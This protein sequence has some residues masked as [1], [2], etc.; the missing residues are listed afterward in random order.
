MKIRNGFVSN[1]SSSS[2]ILDKRTKGVEKLIE[3]AQKNGVIDYTDL[4]RRTTVLIGKD[5][6]RRYMSEHYGFDYE[7]YGEYD[8][9]HKLVSL[10]NQLNDNI[11]FMRES[12]EG[13]GGYLFKKDSDDRDEWYKNSKDAEEF[14]KLLNE[15]SLF[16]FEYH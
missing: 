14:Y 4:T 16:T 5:D 9:Y 1:S 8:V 11:V 12:D 10:Y 3:K 13:M 6:F 7:P 2:F 15:L